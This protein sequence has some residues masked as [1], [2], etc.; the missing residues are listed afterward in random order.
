MAD[1]TNGI[2]EGSTN[3]L[4]EGLGS[5]NSQPGPPVAH[6][7]EPDS[8]EYGLGAPNTQT[9]GGNPG[10]VAVDHSQDSAEKGLPLGLG[11]DN[12]ESGPPMAHPVESDDST[13]Y[14]LGAPNTQHGDR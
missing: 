3:G 5:D 10:Y 9:E 4:A 11:S 7:A 2:V 6:P 1:N 14:G 8:L 13:E 12:T